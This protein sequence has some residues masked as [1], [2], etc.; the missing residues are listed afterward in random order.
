MPEQGM[1]RREFFSLCARAGALG[2]MPGAL[3]G[4]VLDGV[5][6][7]VQRVGDVSNEPARYWVPLGGGV[8]KCKLCPRGCEIS[9]GERG[10][11]GVRENRDGRFITKVYGKPAQVMDDAMEKGPFHHYLPATRTLGIGTAGCNLDC[12]YCQSWEFAQA[13]PELT[14]NKNLPPQSLVNQVKAAGG[15]SITFTYSEPIVAIEYVLDT[16][17]YAH[18]NGIRVLV[19]TGGYT[20]SNVMQDLCGAVDA[21]NIDFKAYSHEVYRNITTAEMDPMLESIKIAAASDVW[22]EL[23]SLIVPGYNDTH[24]MVSRMCQWIIANCGATT[25]LHL[26]RFFPQYKFRHIDPTPADTLRQLRKVA[27]NTGMKFV[28]LGNMGGDP[29]ESTYCPACWAKVIERVGYR[30]TNKAL[31]LTTGKCT[32]CGYKIP[33]VWTYS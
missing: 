30:V 14:D 20:C 13:R 10:F 24:D 15:K 19:K 1:D 22:L 26:S 27:Y 31:D 29:A 5:G 6:S 21:I 7:A 32:C 33:G 3:Q 25:P 9:H 11:C 18:Q 23:T 16:A 17:K 12:G 8:T 28:Y 2:L 4:Q